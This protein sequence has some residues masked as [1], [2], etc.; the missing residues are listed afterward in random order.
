ML[1]TVTRV[2]VV[3]P[4]EHRS[5]ALRSGIGSGMGT[6]FIL[7]GLHIDVVPTIVTASMFPAVSVFFGWLY[8]HDHISRAQLLG[9]AAVLLG[10]A[11]VVAG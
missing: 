9:L 8:F 4:R 3:P 5:A 7:V 10:V 6:I 11:G 2:A 1:A